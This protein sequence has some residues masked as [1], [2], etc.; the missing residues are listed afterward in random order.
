MKKYLLTLA[1]VTV[2]LCACA[3]TFTE[4]WNDFHKRTEFFDAN[5]RLTGYKKWND[6]YKRYD[7]FDASGR[8]EGYYKWNDFHN[9]WEY[10]KK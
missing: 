3:Q 10:H 9:R 5:G 8:L 4:K 1:A 7:V 2:A 6:F